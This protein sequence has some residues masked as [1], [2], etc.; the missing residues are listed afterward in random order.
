MN[1]LFFSFDII[2]IGFLEYDELVFRH[3][4]GTSL[5]QHPFW[6][7]RPNYFMNIRL[8]HWIYEKKFILTRKL[9]NIT[10]V[11]VPLL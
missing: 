3:G 5:P 2:Q 10:N 11:C 1:I 4:G 6:F 7:D 9:H 8:V